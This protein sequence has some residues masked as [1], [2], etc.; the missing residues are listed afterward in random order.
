MPTAQARAL[1]LMEQQ[2]LELISLQVSSAA[3]NMFLQASNG[4]VSE[5]ELSKSYAA[6]IAGGMIAV[7]GARVSYLQ[8]FAKANGEKPFKIPSGVLR[9]S[10]ADVLVSGIDPAETIPYVTG[11]QR[12]YAGEL[13]DQRDAMLQRQLRE[14]VAEGVELADKS[15]DALSD[16]EIRRRANIM[17]GNRLGSLAESTVTSTADYVT[18]SVL[19]PDKRVGAL[20][21]VVHPGACD[22]CQ[23]VAQVMTFVY[24]PR[25][26][27][28]QCRCS[29]EPVYVSDPQYQGRL[30][31]YRDTAAGRT[32]G[33]FRGGR[34]T[35]RDARSRGRRQLA[36]AQAR[37]DSQGLRDLWDDFLQG[38]ESRS[39]NLVKTIKSN[40]FKDWD[41]MVAASSSKIAGDV[42]PV[43]TRA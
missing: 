17:A 13:F 33:P 14:A 2:A 40:T 25:L 30:A 20:R 5:E 22:R 24:K 29:F 7:A 28:D 4:Q 36:A 35:A 9:P 1:S 39:N 41:V 18:R 37:E 23:K 26:R 11:L 32:P 12:K 6:L 38:E 27:H 42:F 10:P 15:Y 21:R 31:Q 3:Q 34:R 43:L 8:G 19:A 16:A